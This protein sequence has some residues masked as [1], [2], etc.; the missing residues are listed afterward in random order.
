MGQTKKDQ[1]VVW[2]VGWITLTILS[3]F[4]SSYFWTGFIAKHFGDMHKAGAPALWVTAVFGTWML[5]LVP[6][7]IVMYNKVDK[8]YEDA[9][10]TR[11]T[12]AFQKTKSEFKIRSI[13]IEESKRLLKPALS[14]KLKQLP[15]IIKKG[16][17]VTAIL[18]DGRRIEN[19]FVMAKREVLGLYDQES[20]SF[21][22]GDI[23]DFEPAAEIPDFKAGKWL[24][25]DGVG[26]V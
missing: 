23:V 11:E 8:A 22:I 2:W 15:E 13:L 19:V 16:H 21:E 1:G 24:R 18:K 12:A 7:I 3:F 14:Q 10:I 6:L 4:A 20:L 9:R 26:M 17:L 25:L 5:F